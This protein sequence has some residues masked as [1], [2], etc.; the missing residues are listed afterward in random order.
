MTIFASVKKDTSV[1][2]FH[3]ESCDKFAALQHII[4]ILLSISMTQTHQFNIHFIA[5][6][7]VE[8]SLC[9]ANPA[10]VVLKR[11]SNTTPLLLYLSN[12]IKFILDDIP[13]VDNHDT[14]AYQCYSSGEPQ[15][16]IMN[17]TCQIERKSTHINTPCHFDQHIDQSVEELQSVLHPWKVI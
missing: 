13:P 7:R 1:F 16:F 4:F 5:Y 8:I 12:N 11:T 9:L 10:L 3:Y 17:L 14:E 6:I 15:S 2:I